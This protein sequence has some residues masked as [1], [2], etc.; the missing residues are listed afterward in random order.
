MKPTDYEDRIGR[1]VA[2][3]LSEANDDLPHDITERLK[4][5][6]MQALAKRKVVRLSTASAINANGGGSA[7]LSVG[8]GDKNVWTRFGVW[9]PFVLL[10]V[11]LIVIP[12]IQEHHYAYEIAEVDSALLADE[13][14]PAAYTDQGFIH[15]MNSKL[16]ASRH[17]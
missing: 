17:E 14:P 6:R 3:R 8:D 5:A 1:N 7:T 10:V 2:A 11:G 16:D 15:F 9:L 4:A 13:L 12:M